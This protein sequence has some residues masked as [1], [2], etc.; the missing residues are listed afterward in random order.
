LP[1]G[2]GWR[3]SIW[4]T[5][6]PIRCKGC[7]NPVLWEYSTGKL[8]NKEALKKIRKELERDWIARSDSTWRRTS[9]FMEFGSDKRADT[10]GLEIR[11]ELM[12]LDWLSI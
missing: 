2:T 3:V 8:Y 4:L 5:G 10:A 7:F 1:T 9:G 11:K 6:C 12:G